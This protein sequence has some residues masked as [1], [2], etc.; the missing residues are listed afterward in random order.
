MTDCVSCMYYHFIVHIKIASSSKKGEFLWA[1]IIICLLGEMDVVLG[2]FTIVGLQAAI[3]IVVVITVAVVILVVVVITVAI[4][5]VD[6]QAVVQTV[7]HL[8]DG[9]IVLKI[10]VVVI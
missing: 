8:V 4:L 6:L 7:V 10:A 1:V 3:I 9:T 5:H 2:Q